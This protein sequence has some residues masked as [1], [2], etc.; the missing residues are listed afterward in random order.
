MYYL[1]FTKTINNLN[2]LQLELTGITPKYQ[3]MYV[4]G[5]YIQLAFTT[6]LTQEEVNAVSSHINNF[7]EVCITEQLKYYVETKI[8]PFVED[9]LFMI[10]AQNIEMGIT[11][12]GKTWEVLGFFEEP[13]LLD[14]KTR[15][16]SFK[17]SLDANSLTVTIELLTYFIAH[18]EMYADLSPFVTVER[19]S[20]WKNM[21]IAKL[22]E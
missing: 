14:G 21:I 9:L 18:P 1:E 13:V 3:S 17:G 16:V 12:L 6:N 22:S 20:T 11:Q 8:R 2:K 19:L 5:D 7:V 10:Q 15:K 4:K